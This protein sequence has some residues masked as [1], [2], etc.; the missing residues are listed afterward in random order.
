MITGLG[1]R[2]FASR[3]I[4]KTG[5]PTGFRVLTLTR[6]DDSE[7]RFSSRVLDQAAFYGVL[8]EVA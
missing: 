6:E 4:L 8:R 1:C 3:D 7:T 2:K 5:G